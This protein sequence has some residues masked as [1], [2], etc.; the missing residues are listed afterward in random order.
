[1]VSLPNTDAGE[2]ISM[3][4]VSFNDMLEMIRDEKFVC[5]V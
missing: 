5:A 4:L 2:K 1:M 3:Q